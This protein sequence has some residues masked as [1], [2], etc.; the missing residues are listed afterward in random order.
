M[1]TEEWVKEWNGRFDNGG[2]R[3]GNKN[4]NIRKVIDKDEI[5]SG[6]KMCGE[7]DE[8]VAHVVSE[9]GNKVEQKE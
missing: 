6:L 4:E 2:A 8:T 9:S 3:T 7:R 5:D 1:V